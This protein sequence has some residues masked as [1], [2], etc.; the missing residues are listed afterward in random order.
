ML[1]ENG[2]GGE[3]VQVL[4]VAQKVVLGVGSLLFVVST[5]FPTWEYDQ[6]E[7]YY[8]RKRSPIFSPPSG[9]D[10]RF[11]Q[12][13]MEVAAIVV[14]TGA[15]LIILKGIKG[16]PRWPGRMLG[17]ILKVPFWTLDRILPDETK[18][19]PPAPGKRD[20]PSCGARPGERCKDP[21]G[22]ELFSYHSERNKKPPDHSPPPILPP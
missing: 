19:L 3:V 1:A 20:C 8:P 2:Q 22:N 5:L 21:S 14:T 10:V 9:Y 16:F 11:E 4:N 7:K 17:W 12:Y 15:A 13:F 6:M 18:K